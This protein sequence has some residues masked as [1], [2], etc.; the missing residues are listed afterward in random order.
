M[1]QGELKAGNGWQTVELAQPAKGRFMALECRSTHSGKA[2]AVAELYLRGADGR[3]LSREAWT[4]KYADSE[5]L[6]GNHTGDKAFDLQESTY[7]QT[8]PGAPMPHLLVID[9]GEECTVSGI[10]FLP[11]AEQGA[12]ESVKEFRLFVYDR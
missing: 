9:L 12:P 3:R 2:C 10:E 8:E 7:W 5:N 1:A 6:M 4:V 11:R